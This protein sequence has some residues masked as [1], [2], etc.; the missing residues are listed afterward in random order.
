[1]TDFENSPEKKKAQVF[2]IGKARLSP[3]GSREDVDDLF[4]QGVVALKNKKPKEAKVLFTRV[5]EIDPSNASAWS[6]L[7][8][9]CF[10]SYERREAIDN[11]QRAINCD[12]SDPDIHYRLAS[13]LDFRSEDLFEARKQF[14]IYLNLTKNTKDESESSFRAEA[15]EAIE[16]IDRMIK[17]K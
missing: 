16:R 7:A 4:E 13:V 12:P 10:D 2:D 1:M 15:E 17:K 9:A 3:K 5:V 14:K 6:N 11:Y 8:D